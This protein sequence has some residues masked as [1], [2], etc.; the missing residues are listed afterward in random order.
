MINQKESKVLNDFFYNFNNP[1]AFS[2]GQR[3]FEHLTQNGHKIK[4]KDINDWLRK[5][6]TYTL[7]RD[8]HLN[9]KR[10]SYNISNIDDLWE[11]DLMDMQQISR[12]NKGFKYILAVIDCFS[13]FAWCI[14]IKRKI[15]SEVVNAFKHIFSH[16]KRRPVCIQS[17]KGREF[18]NRTFKTYLS[19]QNIKFQTTKDPSTKA[20]ICERFIRTIKSIIFKYFTHINTNRYIDVLDGILH[21]YNNRKHSAIGTAPSMVND[22]NV[23]KIWRFMKEK[24]TPRRNHQLPRCDVGDTVRVANPKKVFDKGYRQKWSKEK[25][26]ITKRMMSAPITYRICDMDNVQI[27]G[28]FYESEIQKIAA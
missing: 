7:H 3:L 6:E 22:E 25:F 15:P 2:S 9:F 13:K 1:S 26:R 27:D 20:A 4:K 8:R 14:A 24:K 19:E 12:T 11:I 23:L 21:I 16:T 10:R 5:Q 18:D 17:D 28:N